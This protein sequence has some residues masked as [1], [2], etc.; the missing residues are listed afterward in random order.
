MSVT[1]FSAAEKIFSAAKYIPRGRENIPRGKIY[2]PR[3][4]KYSPRQKIFPAAEKIFPA[5]E[6]IFPAANFFLF[7]VPPRL[8]YN[9][10]PK[11]TKNNNKWQSTGWPYH[12]RDP[13]FQSVIYI[14]IMA[15]PT[16]LPFNQNGGDA[17]NDH[18]TGWW[19]LIRWQGTRLVAQ[20]RPPGQHVPYPQ[21]THCCASRCGKTT[22]ASALSHAYVI[23]VATV[24]HFQEASADLYAYRSLVVHMTLA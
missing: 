10:Q 11:T 21:L 12:S 22:P 3:P 9:W 20:Q 18:H 7:Y 13:D 6:K 24:G 19:H 15:N 16:H 1:K 2:S 8:P 14:G 17:A 4:K 5:V 23:S